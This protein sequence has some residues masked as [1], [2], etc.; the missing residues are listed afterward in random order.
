MRARFVSLNDSFSI[1]SAARFGSGAMILRVRL[2]PEAVNY[3]PGSYE[4]AIMRCS[5]LGRPTSELGHLRKSPSG[6]L[7]QLSPIADAP[8]DRLGSGYSA[9]TGLPHHSK[10]SLLN[11]LVGAAEQWQ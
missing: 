9:T 4:N 1:E 6:P 8:L 11:D 10:S 7:C 2:T 3:R 5:K